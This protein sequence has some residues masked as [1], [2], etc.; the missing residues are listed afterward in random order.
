M[1]VAVR[2]RI[3]VSSR[4]LQPKIGLFANEGES[5]Y[6]HSDAEPVFVTD[7]DRHSIMEEPFVCDLS[8]SSVNYAKISREHRGP[9]IGNRYLFNSN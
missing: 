9:D 4:T 7:R 8:I 1:D 3:Y 5:I 6:G 2:D